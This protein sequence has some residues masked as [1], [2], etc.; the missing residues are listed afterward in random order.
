MG[1]DP[2]PVKRMREGS[3]SVCVYIPCRLR[4]AGRLRNGSV[5]DT[6]VSVS[7]SVCLS[8]VLCLVSVCRPARPATAFMA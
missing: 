4:G 3:A 8:C 5:Y 1:L 6:P 2:P 7:V